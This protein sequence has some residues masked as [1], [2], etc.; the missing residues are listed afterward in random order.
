LQSF[1]DI[2]SKYT[3][4]TTAPTV[5]PTPSSLLEQQQSATISAASLLVMVY[6][7]ERGQGTIDICAIIDESTAGTATNDISKSLE[8]FD[9]DI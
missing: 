7:F 3:T 6:E 5:E 9:Q 4:T 8:F 1:E 2:E